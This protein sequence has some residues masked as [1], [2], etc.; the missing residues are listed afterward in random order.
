MFEHV[1]MFL[2]KHEGNVGVAQTVA[3]SEKDT[4][5]AAIEKVQEDYSR[6]MCK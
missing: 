1:Y 3:E 5:Y 2:G 6:G 4:F